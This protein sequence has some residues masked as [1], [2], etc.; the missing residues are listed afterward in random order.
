[1]SNNRS[2]TRDGFGD[3]MIAIGETNQNV[4]ALTADLTES[5]RLAA[6]EK[7]FPERF[8]Q[9]GVAEQQLAG[10]SAGLALADKIPVAA[11]YAAFQPANSWGVI[12]TSIA[13]QNLNV[14]LVGAHAGL[15]TGP[16][17]AT[18]QSLE[19]IAL[20]R[21]LP[22]FTVL[23]PADYQEAREA[24]QVMVQHTGP[25]Y[26]RISK[27][28]VPAL[29]FL[30]PFAIG[31]MRTIQA[32]SDITIIG[33]GAVFSEVLAANKQLQD[34]GISV[35]ILNCSSIKPLDVATILTAAR[36]T[37]G[38]IT[39]EDHQIAGGMGSAIAEVL[40]ATT[41]GKPCIRLGVQDMFGE[42]GQQPELYK[43]FKISAQ[44]I[45]ETAAR[46]LAKKY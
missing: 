3:A 5:V 25:T 15:A 4:F 12:R 28:S 46:I 21:V 33:T 8:V 44:A 7:N 9:V 30:E 26:L 36:E 17:G 24:T 10:I 43:K 40:A 22:N 19:D 1:M 35:R 31:K 39:I 23:Q 29:Q 6:F 32:G 14:K 34:E 18:H 42:S 20:M 16:D 41:L 13:L 2:S 11:S 45:T 37:T 27:I 38:I